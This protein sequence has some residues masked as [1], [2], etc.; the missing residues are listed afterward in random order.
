MTYVITRKEAL[1]AT[2]DM[3]DPVVLVETTNG[4]AMARFYVV[5]IDDPFWI[6]DNSP[7]I[8]RQEFNDMRSCGILDGSLEN[9]V[10]VDR[11]FAYRFRT[12]DHDGSEQ[13]V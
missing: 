10:K 5:D 9:R 1:A 3:T 6:S 8:T 12:G 2:K 13:E 4:S 11:L 7:E